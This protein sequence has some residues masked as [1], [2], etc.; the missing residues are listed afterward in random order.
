MKSTIDKILGGFL[1]LLM[2]VMTLDVLYGVFTRYV[3]GDQPGWTE[4]VARF[5]LIWIGILGAAYA[6]GQGN[7]LSIDLISGK[8]TDANNKRLS[9]FVNLLILAFAIGVLIVGGIRLIYITSYL[10]QTSPALKLPMSIIYSV[11]P[12]SGLLIVVYKLM[13]F[14][15]KTRTTPEAA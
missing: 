1:A 5:L 10:G 15:N 11:L 3:L 7:H 14:F 8:L 6:S 4:E 2:A 13:A 9:V 12:L